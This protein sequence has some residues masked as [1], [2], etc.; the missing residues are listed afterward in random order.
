MKRDTEL[1]R[2]ILFAVE[3]SEDVISD[4]SEVGLDCSQAEFFY[5]VKIMAQAE[6]L[7]A[8]DMSRPTHDAYYA[9]GLTWKGQELLA[10]IRSDTVWQKTKDIAGE[11]MGSISLAV[12]QEMA[13]GVV[14]GLFNLP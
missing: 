11:K 5:H 4:P 6:F 2:K 14:R 8:Y 9:T 12:I 13:K 3:A 7:D 10:E 1:V